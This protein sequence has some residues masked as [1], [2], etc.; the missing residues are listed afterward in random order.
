MSFPSILYWKWDDHHLQSGKY[1]AQIADIISRSPFSHIYIT[2]H[3]CHEGLTCPNTLAHLDRACKL[4]HN[5]GRKMILEVDVRA[6]KAAFAKKHPEDRAGF[7]YWNTVPRAEGSCSFSIRGNEG[8]ELFGGDRQSG[9]ALLGAIAYR[10]DANGFVIADSLH[11]IDA[12]V[13]RPNKDSVSVTWTPANTGEQIF[14]AVWSVFDFPDLFSEAY[15]TEQKHLMELAATISPDGAALDELCFMW[16]PDFDFTAGSYMTLDN[17]PIYSRGLA[18][19]YQK[20]FD[21]DYILDML[22]RFVS[23]SDDPRRIAASNRYFKC[24]REGIAAA[25][26][27][28]YRQ[29]KQHL[30][31]NAF[32]GAHNTW[33][34][35]EEVQNSPEIWRT[36]I[37]WWSARKDYG[38]T[39]EIML[40]PVRTALAHKA[41]APV[42]YNMWYSEG[43]MELSTFYTEMWRNVRY[44]G[45]TISLS[46]ECINE[47]H[48]VQ[49]LCRPGELEAI[50]AIESEIRGVDAFVQSPARC[51]IAVVTSL[52]ALCNRRENLDGNGRWDTF[53]GKLKEVFTLARDLWIAGWN[54]DMIGDNEIYDHNLAVNKD[55]YLAYG[56]QIYTCLILAFP[57]YAQPGLHDMLQQVI[58][59]GK[60]RLIFV[61]NGDTGF[62]GLP[63]PSPRDTAPDSPFFAYRPEI[64]DI[65]ALLTEWGV[66]T[67]RVPSGCVMQDG[68]IILT[69]SAPDKPVGNPLHSQ[70][71]LDKTRMTVDGTDVVC[72]RKEDNKWNIWSPHK[73]YIRED[74]L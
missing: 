3:W 71:V 23:A 73:V 15:Y 10:T 60:T 68:S 27:N 35:I 7:L 25:E 12:S 33:F 36:G 39:D 41:S 20:Q 14:V 62:D 45:R 65:T 5:A 66:R 29:T 38:F 55:G 42:F 6:E 31:E 24:L 34:C 50:A 22:Y 26:N 72:L 8:G 21:A 64:G 67:N 43:T 11:P 54:C 48:I 70:F 46:Y 52:A 32:V 69:A 4:I 58:S 37:T 13:Y 17:C 2:T 44:G 28:F 63:M 61:G 57:Q 18:S 9:D 1:A 51:D 47:S 53:S 16:H 40:Y 56:N 19:A 74:K 30:G 49:Q 59:Y